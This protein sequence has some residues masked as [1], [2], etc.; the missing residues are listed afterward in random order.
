[1]HGDGESEVVF[2][3]SIPEAY[4]RYL[5]PLIFQ[6]YA[7]D[8]ASRVESLGPGALLEVAAGTGAVTRELA[9]RLPDTT[10]ITAT[11]ISRPMLDHASAIGTAR[12]VTWRQADVMDL[13]FGDDSFDAVVCQFG[14]MFFPD[15]PRAF[16]EIRRVLRPGGTFVFN[17]WGG[18]DE[19]DFIRCVNEA[20]T[21]VFPEDPPLFAARVA[22]G[23]HDAAV[24]RGDL[25]SGGFDSRASFEA[26]DAYSRAESSRIPAI[27]FC[28]GTPLRNWIEARGA[29]RLQEATAAAASA[30]EQ[31]FGPAD[32]EGKIRGYVITVVNT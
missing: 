17:V 30:I 20:L 25:A 26:I 32:V 8:L 10:L 2:A 12:P 13:P 28:E 18:L 23:Y 4:D 15:R 14:V 16:A 9:T 22:H 5:V 7:T 27:G 3:G 29:S 24:I 6:P 11:D 1:M 21:A 19:N 31:H